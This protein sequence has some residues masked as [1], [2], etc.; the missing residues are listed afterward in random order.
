[1]EVIAARA[2]EDPAAVDAARVRVLDDAEAKHIPPETPPGNEAGIGVVRDAV[3]SGDMAPV[4]RMMTEQEAQAFGLQRTAVVE[5]NASGESSASLEAQSRLA[6]ESANGQ[7]RLLVDK[8]GVVRPLVG[9]D[10]VDTHA[11]AGQVIL[12]RGIGAKEWTVL[13]QGDNVKAGGVARARAQAEAHTK[14]QPSPESG[15][16][17]VAPMR[18]ADGGGGVAARLPGRAVGAA[19]VGGGLPPEAMPSSGADGATPPRDIGHPETPGVETKSAGSEIK[20]ATPEQETARLSKE[21][22]NI[23]EADPDT[24]VTL[25]GHDTPMKLSDAIELIDQQTKELLQQGDL[26]QAAAACA[27]MGGM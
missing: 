23:A 12:Q 13:S 3:E 9:V 10:A 22:Q 20:P 17:T 6:Q 18:A 1:M 4:E 26:V 8:D 19:E 15:A 16:S 25:P 5:N 27:I 24:M 11:A 2:A 14:A 7:V 21:V